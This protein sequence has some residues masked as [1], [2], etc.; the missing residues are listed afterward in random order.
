M[1]P[2]DTIVRGGVRLPASAPR[3]IREKYLKLLSSVDAEAEHA[4]G[5]EGKFFRPGTVLTDAELRP[6]DAFPLMPIVL[7]FFRG[8][9]YGIP[10]HRRSDYVYILWRYDDDTNAWRE[11][12]RAASCAWEWAVELRPIAVRALREARG[13]NLEIMPD[14][15]AIAGRIALFLDAELK[16]LEPLHRIKV[17]GVLHDAFAARLCA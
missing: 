10:G 2:E 3:N 6:T 5:F 4:F 7:E 13:A 11:L 12:G 17:L 15:P 9:A 16:P 1:P 8:P 14:F